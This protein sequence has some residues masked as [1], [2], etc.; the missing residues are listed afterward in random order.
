[1]NRFESRLRNYLDWCTADSIL[2]VKFEDIIQCIAENDIE[3]IGKICGHMGVQLN[4][5][6]LGHVLDKFKTAGSLTYSGKNSDAWS[7]VY[8]PELADLYNKNILPIAKEI[9]YPKPVM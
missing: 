3:Y 5:A 4:Q 1:M 8:T 2:L 9:G 7:D 6:D